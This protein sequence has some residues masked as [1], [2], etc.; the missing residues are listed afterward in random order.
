VDL[1]VVC[2]FVLLVVVAFIGIL[3]GVPI[4]GYILLSFGLLIWGI[5]KLVTRVQRGDALFGVVLISLA[6]GIYTNASRL[7]QWNLR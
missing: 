3:I 7:P 2:G 5:R 4:A 1:V 6:I